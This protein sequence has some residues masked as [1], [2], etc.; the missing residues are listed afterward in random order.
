MP[1][2]YFNKV[3]LQLCVMGTA[4]MKGH[5]LNLTSCITKRKGKKLT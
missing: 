5:I 1:K 4:T 3:A 2:C